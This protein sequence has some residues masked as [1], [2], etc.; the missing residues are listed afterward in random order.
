MTETL[1]HK[2]TREIFESC[3]D[4]GTFEILFNSFKDS[5]TF[6]NK[7]YKE[8]KTYLVFSSNCMA[9]ISDKQYN[10]MFGKL[11]QVTITKED[12]L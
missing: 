7:L 4:A 2:V 10:F 5:E 12:T 1:A 3:V 9:W 11:P 8:D 6:K